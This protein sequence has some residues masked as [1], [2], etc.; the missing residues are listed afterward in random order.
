MTDATESINVVKRPPTWMLV[1]ANAAIVCI[2]TLPGSSWPFG[3]LFALIGCGLL[4]GISAVWQ[5]LVI[6]I[7]RWI[8]LGAIIRSLAFVLP[9]VLFVTLPLLGVRPPQPVNKKNPAVSPSGAYKAIISSPTPCWIV[10]IDDDAG[11]IFK[12]E[13]DFVSHLN[14]YWIWDSS[15]RLWVYNSDD[16]QVHSWARNQDGDWR[17][18]RWG[19]AKRGGTGWTHSP[20]DDL[21]PDYV[22]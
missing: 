3:I 11:Q 17:H 12:E 2:T 20:P 19:S 5:A 13:T 10:R 16:G 9:S 6:L 21:Y 15:D 18:V 7:E 1:A 4:I 8:K 14:I 22:D